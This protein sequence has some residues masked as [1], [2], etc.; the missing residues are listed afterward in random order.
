MSTINTKRRLVTAHA[1]FKPHAPNWTRWQLK[2]APR[3][4]LKVKRR[5]FVGSILKKFQTA[6]VLIMERPSDFYHEQT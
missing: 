2:R 4:L 3:A 6:K 5:Q 1:Q